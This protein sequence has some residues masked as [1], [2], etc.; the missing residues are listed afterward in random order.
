MHINCFIDP[1]TITHVGGIFLLLLLIV[2]CFTHS[3]CVFLVKKEE[4]KRELNQISNNE[5]RFLHLPPI[6]K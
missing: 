2:A 6:S 3:S 5:T 1:K 4:E